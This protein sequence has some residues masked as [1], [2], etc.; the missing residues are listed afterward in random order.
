MPMLH[1]S[2]ACS[3]LALVTQCEVLRFKYQERARFGCIGF[4]L[5][6]TAAHLTRNEYE[7]VGVGQCRRW[8]KA[9]QSKRKTGRSGGGRAKVSAAHTYVGANKRTMGADYLRFC[10][11]RMIYFSFV[12]LPDKKRSLRYSYM[13]L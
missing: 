7:V 2:H 1:A 3:H 13:H 11:S 9:Q 6:T 10:L 5:P 4:S 12:P 8:A